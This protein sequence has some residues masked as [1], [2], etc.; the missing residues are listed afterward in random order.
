M[1]FTTKK[2]TAAICQ[3]AY[4]VPADHLDEYLCMGGELSSSVFSSYVNIWLNY[5]VFDT[6]KNIMLMIFIILFKCMTRGTN[7]LTCWTTLILC[8]G[9][10]KCR[11]TWTCQFTRGHASPT[12]MLEVV[13]SQD[14]SIWHVFFGVTR[15]CN[16]INVVY[17][18]TIFN[19]L[20]QENVLE[21]N[22]MVN[23]TQ[24]TKRYYIKD[25]IYPEWATFM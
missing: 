11:V 23:E 22:F 3:L 4:A 9:N 25:K 1:L 10:E 5:L 14:L 16:D 20:L 12:I 18:S 15:S 2:C 21:I 13:V 17:E 7:S 24:Y 6:W 8:I 19:K